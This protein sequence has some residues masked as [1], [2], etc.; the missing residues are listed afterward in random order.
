MSADASGQVFRWN[1]DLLATA[2][3]D[4]DLESA[5]RLAARMESSGFKVE[6]RA[7]ADEFVEMVRHG[8]FR[9]IVV[10]A[11][12][13]NTACARFLDR[14]R[15]TAPSSWLIVANMSV[16]PAISRLAR[17]HDIDVLLPAPVDA[18]ELMRRVAALQAHARSL[19]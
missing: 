17:R 10:V 13:E 2:I 14:L 8:D 15:R 7:D 19:S 6:R 11:D 5:A 12:L 16:G 18:E 3:F 4:P 1:A 9:T